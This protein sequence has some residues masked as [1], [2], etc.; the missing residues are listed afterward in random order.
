MQNIFFKPKNVVI[1]NIS[2]FFSGQTA[3]LIFFGINAGSCLFTSYYIKKWLPSRSKIWPSVPATLAY[4]L[5]PGMRFDLW[6]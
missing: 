6:F 5:V 4:V 3:N 1:A 2:V